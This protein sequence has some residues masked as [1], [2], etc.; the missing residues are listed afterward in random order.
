PLGEGLDGQYSQAPLYREDAFDCTTYVETVLANI[1][2]GNP[3]DNMVLIRYADGQIDFFKRNH[4]MENMWIPNALKHGFISRIPLRNQRPSFLKVDLAEW[5][6]KNPEVLD[7]QDSEF[8]AIARRQRPF[9]ASVPYVPSRLV[10]RAYLDRLYD[11]ILVFFFKCG[12]RPVIPGQKDDFVM[13]THMG[14]LVNKTDLYHAS[15]TAGRVKAEDFM[16]YLRSNPDICGVSFYKIN[17]P[18]Q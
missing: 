2:P 8:Q 17:L 5:Y 16:E 11:D 3:V 10:N 12:T 13:I 9:T 7:A 18:Q 15:R 6:L 4:F 1:R 14:I